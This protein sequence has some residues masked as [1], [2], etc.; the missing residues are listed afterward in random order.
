MSRVYTLLTGLLLSLIALSLQA[1]QLTASVDRTRLN[2]GETVELT[3]ET[4]DVTQFGKPDMSSLEASFEVRDTRQLN[5]LKTLDGSS[6]ATTRWIV[7]LLPRETGSVIIPSLQ[8][9][10][11]KSQPLTLQVM[12]SETKEPASHLASIF[13][14]AS[15]DQDSVYVQAQAVLTLRVYHS[16]SLFDDSS[17]SPLQVPDARVEK[18]GDARTYEKLINGV[19]HGVIE[20]RYAIYPQQ[21]GVLTIPSQVFSATLVQPPAEAQGQEANPFGPQPGKS[22]RVKSAEVPLTVKPKPANYPADI[23]WLPARSISLEENWSP[24]PGTTQVGDSLTRTI[25]LKAEGLAGAQL[26]PLAPTEVPSLRRYPDQPQLRN[27]PSERGLI[28]TREEREALVPGRAGAIELPAVEV[29][30]WNTRED[31]LEHTSLP[32]RTL[33]I[34][35]NPGLAVDTPVSNDQ[36]GVTVIGP[37]VWPWQLSTLLFVCTTLLGLALWWRAR[38]QPAIARTVQA[39]PSPR[40]VLDDLKRACLANDPQ[41]TRQAL[42]AWARQQPETL[43]EMAARFVPLSDALD[44]LNGAL[45]SETGKLW[46][47]EDLWRAVRKL[48]AAEHIQDPAG[49]AGLP[50]LYP[51]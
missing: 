15:L 49:D 51:K 14:E 38:G 22:V 30:W 35:N 33:Q 32:A 41:G 10:E 13:I 48:P 18:L 16:V 2:A 19:R 40:T 27:L 34:S 3:L 31:Y 44:G 9:G 37:P 43:A 12:Q 26:P 20:T 23:A 36:G 29:T 45:Y 47:G 6:Q 42:D 17:L 24:E 28:G 4:D 39:G 21:S 8:L 11:L 1:A 5:S 7:T 50:P 25:T 46:L